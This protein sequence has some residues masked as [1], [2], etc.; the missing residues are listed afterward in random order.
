MKTLFSLFMLAFLPA[1]VFA[2]WSNEPNQNT[3]IAIATGEQVIPKVAVHPDGTTYVCWFSQEAG[4]YNVRLQKLDIF[5]NKLWADAGMLISNNP[6]MSWLT[7]WDMTVDHS[8]YAVLVFQDI[9]TGSNNIYAY[10]ISPEGEFVWGPNGL[11]LSNNSDFEAAPV[12]TITAQ[13]NAVFAWTRESTIS[14]QKVNP[15]G[16][17]QWGENGIQFQGPTDFAWPK[18]IPVNDDEIL[19][20]FFKQTGQFPAITKNVFVQRFNA[21]GQGV[22]G[23]GIAITNNAGIPFYVQA[24]MIPDGNDGAFITWHRTPGNIF[25]AYV[26]HV[27]EDGNL[28]F[29][30]NG[31]ALSLNTG[32]HQLDPVLAFDAETE[33]LYAFWREHNANQS[34]RG[35]SGQRISSSGTRLWGNN[36][37][38]IVAMQSGEKAD[39]SATL[40]ENEPIIVF[41][42]SPQASTSVFI[43][44]IRL[45]NNGDAVWIGGQRSISL[46]SSNKADVEIT[47]FVNGQMIVV[48]EDERNDGGDIY[49]QNMKPNGTLGPL[50]PSLTVYPQLLQFIEPSH[51]I[52]A[53]FV[54]KNIFPVTLAI[55]SL[56]EF[57]NINDLNL[58]YWIVFDETSPLIF[59]IEF[60]QGDSIIFTVGWDILLAPGRGNLYDTIFIWSGE[61]EYHV[62]IEMDP[63]T[64]PSGIKETGSTNSLK[65]WP[66]PFSDQINISFTN[67]YHEPATLQI[68]DKM[69]KMVN[70]LNIPDSGS[71][72][73]RIVWNGRN[74]S[75]NKSLPGVYFLRA[76]SGGHQ[77]VTR[78]V[79]MPEY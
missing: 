8:G 33:D 75:G 7:D 69:G 20:A 62:I 74:A 44:A 70:A 57:G 41:S 76:L 68:F 1:I 27:K 79:Y 42:D 77:K 23:D 3:A 72:N 47:G 66:N 26:Q 22:W 30:A 17:K 4:N 51:F 34:L 13:N 12:V 10:R 16:Q 35:I 38:T 18:I 64:F 36:G 55:D 73:V 50:Q 9:R 60:N 45:D 67:P 71:E 25:D 48:W 2:Q 32:T 15:A 53:N 56:T 6:S 58:Y 37:K 5:G 11:A 21:D 52:D 29:P 14:M 31:V 78:V 19:M 24:S 43:R 65:A 28:S 49:A 54:V 61:N 46:A 59:P 63:A 40:T 39:L